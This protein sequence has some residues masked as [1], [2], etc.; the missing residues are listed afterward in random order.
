MH[1][2][3]PLSKIFSGDH[4]NS[5]SKAYRFAMRS[6]SLRGMQISKSEKND[7]PTTSLPNPGYIPEWCILCFKKYII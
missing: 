4:V 3:V 2:I 7:W 1:Q 6:M 5:P